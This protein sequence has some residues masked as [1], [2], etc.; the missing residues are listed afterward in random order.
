MI[1][2]TGWF[3]KKENIRLSQED[4]GYGKQ[5]YLPGG[6]FP[7]ELISMSPLMLKE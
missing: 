3:V 7:F 5:L 4:P 1:E 2:C 6:E